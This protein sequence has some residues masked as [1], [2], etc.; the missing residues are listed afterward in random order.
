L[1]LYWPYIL[2]DYGYVSLY[3]QEKP[4]AKIFD[5]LSPNRKAAIILFL[6]LTLIASIS[7]VKLE[8]GEV[9]EGVGP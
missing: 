3:A 6:F 1:L 9:Y 2:L 7:T 5:P 8:T 4:R